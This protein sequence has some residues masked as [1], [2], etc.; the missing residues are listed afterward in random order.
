M[1]FTEGIVYILHWDDLDP[2]SVSFKKVILR[3]HNIQWMNTGS[4][5]GTPIKPDF[6][7]C[8]PSSLK[9]LLFLI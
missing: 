2:A 1:W 8:S 4:L 6:M 3:S 7:A 9:Y 5:L